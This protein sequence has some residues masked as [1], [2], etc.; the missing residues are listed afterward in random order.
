MARWTASTRRAPGG[1]SPAG[2]NTA[3]QVGGILSPIALA[4]IVDRYND[5]FLPLHIVSALYLAASISWVTIHPEKR[6]NPGHR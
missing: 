2:M 5:W 1:V 3:C 4:Y 6:P